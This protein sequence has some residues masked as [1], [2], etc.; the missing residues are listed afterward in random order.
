MPRPDMRR[1]TAGLE[2][3]KAPADAEVPVVKYLGV[4][5]FAVV[6]AVAVFLFQAGSDD[7]ESTSVL[8]VGNSY[9]ASNDLSGV[10]AALGAAGGHDVDVH[11]VAEGG[12]W[13]DDHV[14]GGVVAA[15]LTGG[16]W[17]YVV[18]QEQSVVP[19]SG[20]ERARAM[21]PAIRELAD[22]AAD[23]ETEMVLFLT[24]ARRDGFPD[25]GYNS[26]APMQRAVTAAYEE[27]GGE[28]GARIAPVGEAWAV[29]AQSF[30]LYESD[31]SH[32]TPTGTY[33]AA[34]TIYTAVFGEDPRDLDFDGSLDADTARS[35]RSVAGRVVLGDA[36]R[37]G[38]PVGP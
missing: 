6:V 22:T 11:V 26:Y 16:D 14:S 19:A 36:E 7:G 32:P 28:V 12:A 5:L 38:V 2:V 24:W 20:T 21:F 37:W 15:Q 29:A 34:A 25:V 3:K 13:L 33:L 10:F 8:F 31:G 30:A 27:I 9:T 18:L 17:D 23:W 1:A 35:L 4:L